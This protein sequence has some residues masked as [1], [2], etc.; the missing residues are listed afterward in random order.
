MSKILLIF[1][2]LLPILVLLYKLTVCTNCEKARNEA[3][4]TLTSEGVENAPLELGM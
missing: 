4:N 1:P 2:T 3:I